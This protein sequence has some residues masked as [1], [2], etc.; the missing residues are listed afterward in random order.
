MNYTQRRKVETTANG[1]ALVAG[2][3]LG[4]LTVIPFEAWLLMLVLGAVHSVVLAVPAIGFGTAVLFVIGLHMVIGYAR[5]L[6]R[7]Q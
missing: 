4:F 7:R 2:A 3:C 5:R 6:F 1:A